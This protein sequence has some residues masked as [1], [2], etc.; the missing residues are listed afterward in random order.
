MACRLVVITFWSSYFPCPT[1]RECRLHYDVASPAAVAR[2]CSAARIDTLADNDLIW[3]LS[4]SN[5]AAVPLRDS[6][7]RVRVREHAHAPCRAQLALALVLALNQ[8]HSASGPPLV[9][10]LAFDFRFSPLLAAVPFPIVVHDPS[11]SVSSTGRT[12]PLRIG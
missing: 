11:P 3:D 2:C 9:P 12:P 7:A 10:T 8:P 1:R 4:Y 5:P 6:W